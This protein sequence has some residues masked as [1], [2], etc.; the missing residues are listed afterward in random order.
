MK[1]ISIL[2]VLLAFSA[3]LSLADTTID[4]SE[5]HA[6]GANIA[7]IEA[8][9]D[10]THGAVIGYS[11]CTGCVWSANCGWIGLGNGP[12]NGWQYSNSSNDDWG[13]NHDG[14]GRLAGYAYGGNV[15][16]ITFE[17]THGQ[18]R[19]NLQTGNMSGY[20][21]GVN[22]GW[23]SL[24][25][26]QAHVRTTRLDTG[27]DSDEDGIPDAWEYRTAGDLITLSGGNHD[28]DDDG[29]SDTD[30]YGADTN[31]LDELNR[32]EIVSIAVEPGTNILAWTCRPT[33][34]YRVMATNA[35]P[36]SPGGSWEDVG[37]GHLGPPATSPTQASI[38][39]TNVA[40]RFYRI[41][42]VLP[43]SE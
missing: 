3:A 32:L 6:Y 4:P 13:V 27:P 28:E 5:H 34:L 8:R 16:W 2:V 1:L 31:P 21:W 35:L 14:Q 11:Y 9:G 37:G 42:A 43:L 12:T 15:G 29:M 39:A 18:P 26:A 23:I 7:W 24:S 36:T 25:N 38:P 19:V 17:Q 40:Q 10:I 22:V 41:H 30:E 20:A 33:R